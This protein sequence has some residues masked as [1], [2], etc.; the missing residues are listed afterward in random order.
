[1]AKMHN[2]NNNAALPD[3]PDIADDDQ[4]GQLIAPCVNQNSDI[5]V[6][7]IFTDMFNGEIRAL[8]AIKRLE[9]KNYNWTKPNPWHSNNDPA[10][11][12]S[13]LDLIFNT[14]NKPTAAVRLGIMY[15]KYEMA[16]KLWIHWPRTFCVI[17]LLY[18]IVT[19]ALMIASMDNLQS[20]TVTEQAIKIILL[21]LLI[22]D[23]GCYLSNW[24][25]LLKMPLEIPMGISLIFSVL[26]YT[27]KNQFGLIL[28][29]MC[30]CYL[31]IS[32]MKFLYARFIIW[33]LHF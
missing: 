25:N 20:Y 29:I 3:L 30:V 1:M 15:H 8:T 11:I 19:R 6:N 24:C 33:L 28:Y 14:L 7:D 13:E 17:N 21:A 12:N 2:I 22:I 27:I 16:K 26:L 32:I 4:P 18:I 5:L 31:L 9:R 10:A 23:I